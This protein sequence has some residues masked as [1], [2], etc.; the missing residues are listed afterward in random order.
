MYGMMER[1][2]RKA[3]DGDKAAFVRLMERGELSMYRAAKAILGREAD[4]ED[5]VQ[6]AVCRAFYKIKDLRKPQYF[7]TWLMRIVINCSCDLLRQRQGTAPLD[8]APDQGLEEDQDLR[9]DVE[10]ALNA[11]G[12]NDR[13]ALTLYYLN[14]MSVKDMAKLLNISQD[15][16]KQRLAHGRK[17]FRQ[18]YE[19]GEQEAFP[20]EDYMG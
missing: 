20:H 9:L 10:G 18:A 5:A 12:E 17:K 15:A 6:E 14:D 4:V 3:Q 19:T 13:L 1:D 16:V 11:L 7:K 2:V 8:L